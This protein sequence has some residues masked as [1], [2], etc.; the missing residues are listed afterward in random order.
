V[1]RD[2]VSSTGPV[3]RGVSLP[4]LPTPVLPPVGY[5]AVDAGPL[6]HTYSRELSD[7]A[8]QFFVFTGGG[9]K[10]VTINNGARYCTVDYTGATGS[11][12]LLINLPKSAGQD[13][14]LKLVI[15]GPVNIPIAV[16][17]VFGSGDSFVPNE[18]P[19]P[20]TVN[21]RLQLELL[22]RGNGVWYYLDQSFLAIPVVLGDD[23]TPVPIN[24][25]NAI[26]R[27]R[28]P[29]ALQLTEIFAS[30]TTPQIGS[31][32]TLDVRNGAGTSL[33]TTQP[34]IAT[35]VLTTLDPGSTAGTLSPTPATLTRLAKNDALRL[36][37][38]ATGSTTGA[39]GLKLWFKGWTV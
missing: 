17:Y 16:N 19:L 8:S 28:A 31:A 32:L 7:T 18:L 35:G 29:S 5:V 20:A 37:V 34:A 30:L 13:K 25:A 23:N 15:R 24:G 9:N 12:T 1:V 21:G 33:F 6:L 3:M 14:E 38:T 22:R 27:L 4:V 10:S 39:T 2:P 26:Y 11:P 36:F